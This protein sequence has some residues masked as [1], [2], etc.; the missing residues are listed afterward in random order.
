MALITCPECSKK[1][2]DNAESC[3][4]CGFPINPTK[5]VKPQSKGCFMQTLNAGCLVFV[6]VIIVGM[7]LSGITAYKFSSDK[8]K[9]NKTELNPKN[10]K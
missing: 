4:N 10:I 5:P 7:V 3:L 8:K 6:I 9:N 1:I 2:S